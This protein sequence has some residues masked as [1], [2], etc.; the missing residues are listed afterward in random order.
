MRRRAASR[1]TTA[2]IARRAGISEGTIYNYFSS[3]G[4]IIK[5]LA[6]QAQRM[7]MERAFSR[8]VPGLQ[9]AALIR[10]MLEGA[11]E[12]AHEHEDLMRAFALNV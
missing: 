7:T 11:F 4:A 3:K 5:A 8:A 10:V 2:Q 12:A 6:E 9:G 1:T